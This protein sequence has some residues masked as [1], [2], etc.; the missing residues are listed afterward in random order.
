VLRLLLL[1]AAGLW[2]AGAL[3]P[4]HKAPTAG[5]WLWE[6]IAHIARNP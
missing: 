3:F 5:A 1:I 6:E 4:F 2:F